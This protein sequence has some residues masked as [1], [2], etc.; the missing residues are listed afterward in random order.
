MGRK[1]AAGRMARAVYASR[2]KRKSGSSES[3]LALPKK[4]RS[5]KSSSKATNGNPVGT[6]AQ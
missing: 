6:R 4:E 5:G 3:K 2:Q 1:W